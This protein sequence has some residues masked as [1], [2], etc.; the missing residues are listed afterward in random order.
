MIDLYDELA[1]AVTNLSQTRIY[2]LCS[3]GIPRQTILDLPLMVGR[4]KAQTSPD[5]FYQ[6]NDDG[7][8]MVIVAEGQPEPPIWDGIDDLI[9]FEPG[10]PGRWYRRRGHIQVLGGHNFRRDRVFPLTIHET[11][12]SYLRAGA[13]GICIIDWRL[14]P[15]TLMSAGPIEVESARLANRMK[16]RAREAAAYRLTI[17]VTEGNRHAA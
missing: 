16:Q 14:D 7:T 8:D 15:E 4:T 5:G 3:L 6:P 13:R 17:S 1:D 12:L 10:D 9:A 2:W 11:P